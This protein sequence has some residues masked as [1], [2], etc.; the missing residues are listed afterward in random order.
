MNEIYEIL[1][2]PTVTFYDFARQT[3]RS[4]HYNRISIHKSLAY[5]VRMICLGCLQLNKDIKARAPSSKTCS[6]QTKTGQERHSSK[7]GN[8]VSER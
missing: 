2:T 1:S 4:T 7:Y 8:H 6:K 5:L 3:S